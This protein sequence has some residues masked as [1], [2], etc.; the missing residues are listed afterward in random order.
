MPTRRYIVMGRVQGV[1]FRAFV[2][3]LAGELGLS[4]EVWNR[5]DGGVEIVAGHPDTAV[6][7]ELSKRLRLGPG[8]VNRV[9]EEAESEAEFGGFEIGPT[10]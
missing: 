8:R 2:A 9:F 7:Q 1:G 10:R 4:G 3:R 6:L 5:R